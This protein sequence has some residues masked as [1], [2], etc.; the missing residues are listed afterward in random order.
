MDWLMIAGLAVLLFIIL[1]ILFRRLINALVYDYVIDAGLSFADNFLAGAGAVGIDIGDWIAAILI[2]INE[3]KITNKWVAAA[4]AWEAT[5]FIPFSFIPVIGEGL[6]IFFNLFPAVTISRIVFSKYR[7]ANKQIKDLKKNISTA[8]MMNIDVSEQREALEKSIDLMKKSDFVQAFEI[9]GN[10]NQ[11][12]TSRFREFCAA[13]I[14]EASD[15]ID[16][17]VGQDIQAPPQFISILEHGVAQT[18]QLLQGSAAALEAEDYEAAITA[19]L[20]AKNTI[21]NSMQQFQQSRQAA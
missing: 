6:E 16:R 13:L 20:N 8:G 15:M 18:N 11:E 14:Q 2:F 9:S 4:V 19:A 17:V 12:L 10:A 1:S 5:N 21:S 7:P 3:R